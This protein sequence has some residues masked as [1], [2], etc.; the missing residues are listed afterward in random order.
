MNGDTDPSVMEAI[1]TA[2]GTALALIIIVIGLGPVMDWMAVY[3]PSIPENPMVNMVLP[4][5]KWFYA[6]I[7]GGVIFTVVFVYKVVIKKIRYSRNDDR[8][9]W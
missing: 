5:F 7:I 8:E 4:L 1:M 6:L 2:M 3:L 9:W